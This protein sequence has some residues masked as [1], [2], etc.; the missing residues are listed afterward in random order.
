MITPDKSK[1]NPSVTSRW[2]ERFPN[3]KRLYRNTLY[4]R[5]GPFLCGLEFDDI[6]GV[7][8]KP[9]FRMLSLWRAQPGHLLQSDPGSI[10]P[11][12]GRRLFRES[13]ISYK[14]P[15]SIEERGMAIYG[16]LYDTF[17]KPEVEYKDFIA[18]LN[19]ISNLNPDLNI[20]TV[21][22]KF[23]RSI[24]LH[25]DNR[26]FCRYYNPYATRYSPY[27]HYCL[28]R[29]NLAIGQFYDRPD[30]F[31]EAVDVYNSTSKY[32]PR[33]FFR[34]NPDRCLETILHEFSDREQFMAQIS[35][36]CED[37][38]IGALNIGQ[39]QFNQ[40]KIV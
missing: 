6:Y 20:S 24:A 9:Y 27:L 14:Y 23:L 36:N 32:W 4:T 38:K 19:Y 15:N 30:I 8:Y 39:I 1:R 2:M 33:R 3:L 7:E 22:F 16:E 10:K 29:I 31:N 28:L 21:K 5:L 37:S 35:K 26:A 13:S 25:V 34:E 12:D 11:S 18:Q 40:M 17:F